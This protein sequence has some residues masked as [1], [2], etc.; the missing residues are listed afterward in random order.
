MSIMREFLRSP[1]LTGAI[2]PSSAT[3]AQAMT[4]GLDLHRADLVVELGSGTGAITGTILRQLAPNARL[5]AVEL[6]PAFARRL[7][8]RYADDSSVEVVQGSAEDLATF[9][10]HP[11]DV[12]VSGLPWTVMPHE[13]QR[14][15][16]DAAAGVLSPS[17]GFS[18]FAYMH[19]AWT[20]PA[21]RFA[22]EL[23]GRFS[24]VERGRVVWPNLPPAYVH[25]AV[26]PVH[27]KS[28]EP[29]HGR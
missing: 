28:A 21:R 10:P 4:A 6:N 17:G 27:R 29:A 16:L 11:V 7:T 15:I 13:R 20:P 8:D 18:T 23:T 2:A 14:R 3:L 12:I 22:T 25:R 24:T 5:I 26:A 1:R 9:V 19:A